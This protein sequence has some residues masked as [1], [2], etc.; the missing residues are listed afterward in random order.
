MKPWKTA[1]FAGLFAIAP[2]AAQAEPG[3]WKIGDEDTTL[4]L[5]GSYHALP[6]DFAWRGPAF[7]GAL[8]A[9]DRI[10]FE[11]AVDD[12]AAARMRAD[13]DAAGRL[14]DGEVLSALLAADEVALVRAAEADLGLPPA[15]LEPFRPWYA[16][17]LITV[18]EAAALGYDPATGVELTIK[19]EAEAGGI[20]VGGLETVEEHLNLFAGLS[21]GASLAY[22]QSVLAARPHTA[23]LLDDMRAAWEGQDLDTLA[24]IAAENFTGHDAEIG[25]RLLWAR[26]ENWI[27]RIE[28]ELD[29]AGTALVVVGATHLG[30]ARGIIAL[31]EA[32]GY[33]ATLVESP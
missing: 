29:E 15:F 6:A 26:N 3:V 32:R 31:L 18:F 10:L 5:F 24:T 14:L 19:A 25:E 12:A 11:T 23:A 22:L 21:D 28:A 17:L 2:M 33:S 1:I 9:A 4:Y 16:A 8:S 7:D 27:P 13:L 20:P 30:G